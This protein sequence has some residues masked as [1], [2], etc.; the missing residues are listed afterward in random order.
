MQKVW[1]SNKRLKDWSFVIHKF[2]GDTLEA[3]LSSVSGISMRKREIP[4]VASMNVRGPGPYCSTSWDISTE[5]KGEIFQDH[6]VRLT[7][8]FWGIRCK[9]PPNLLKF[10][11]SY[12][13]E[14]GG[15][16]NGIFNLNCTMCKMCTM[17]TMCST[18]STLQILKWKCNCESKMNINLI[19]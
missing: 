9:F 3:C 6:I 17:S 18:T 13:E 19:E 15:E 5:D 8:D 10:M 12:S 2:R 1:F 16:L 4:K 7:F 11:Q 14:W